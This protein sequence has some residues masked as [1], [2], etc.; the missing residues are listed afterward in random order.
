MDGVVRSHHKKPEREESVREREG[1]QGVL[2]L[3][4]SPI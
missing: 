1:A 4:K 3:H 2:R